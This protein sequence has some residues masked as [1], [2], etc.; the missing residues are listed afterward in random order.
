MYKVLIIDDEP[1]ARKVIKNLGKFSDLGLEIIDEAD[2]GDTGLKKIETLKPNLVITD[3][4]MPGL[5]GVGLLKA[6]SEQH[7]DVMIIAMSGYND[8]IYLKQAIRSGV[9]EYLLKPVDPIELNKALERCI[10]RLDEAHR[11]T[12]QGFG[13]LHLFDDDAILNEYL[14]YR[15]QIFEGL[16][17][18]EQD[19]IRRLFDGME[20]LFKAHSDWF[21]NEIASKILHDYTQL[22][23]EF[24]VKSG[25]SLQAILGDEGSKAILSNKD[26]ST[27]RVFED[28]KWLYSNTITHMIAALKSKGQLDIN[29]ITSYID[30]HY[31][32]AI[33]LDSIASI[34]YVSKEHLS[35]SF[36][37]QAG[38]TISDYLV[39][40]RMEKAKQLL[41]EHSLAI[42][43]VASMTGYP[44]VAYFYRVFK[45]YTGTAPGEYRDNAHINNVQ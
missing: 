36:K 37:Q 31:E 9:I 14:A 17:A 32:D 25:L 2:D 45:K 18:H 30:K 28:L 39:K 23:E 11:D 5:D 15:Q 21:N 1:W 43:D 22:L 42:K 13:T 19:T 6:I 44:D 3:M 34:F 33:S 7:K 10:K 35:R 41:S 4:R 38:I 27:D 24:V 40:Q 29:Q 20:A 8:F 12:I 16:L 26:I